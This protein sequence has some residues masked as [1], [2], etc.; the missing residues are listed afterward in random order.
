MQIKAMGRR[1]QDGDAAG[2]SDT[3]MAQRK[4]TTAARLAC[5]DPSSATR[6]VLNMSAL[7]IGLID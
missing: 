5:F 3:T 6:M 7:P 2:E 4:Q 1:N